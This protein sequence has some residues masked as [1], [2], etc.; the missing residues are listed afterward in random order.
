MKPFI[1]V[2][3]L[4]A[5]CWPNRRVPGPNGEGW[6]HPVMETIEIGAVMVRSDTLVSVAEFDSFIRP[7]QNPTLSDFCKLLTNIK[8]EDV[9]RAKTY[10]EVVSDFRQWML[11]DREWLRTGQ[12]TTALDL[13]ASWGR[14][15]FNQLKQDSA[16]HQCPFPFDNDEHLNVK[17]H[18]AEKMGWKPQGLGKAL[19][20]LNMD[21]K[22]T[23][24]RGID[25]ARN[26]ARILQQVGL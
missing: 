3:D 15:D 24:H 14:F 10:P 9:D 20:R 26:I 25:D 5:T 12:E 4:E 11:G 22:G 23:P 17:N 6:V 2:V 19:R 7:V 1:I 8:Q 18:V 21:F 13:F 16:Y